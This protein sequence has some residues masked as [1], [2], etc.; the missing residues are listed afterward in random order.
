MGVEAGH[1]QVRG[2]AD[3]CRARRNRG[4]VRH[5]HPGTH[6]VPYV[7]VDA[8]HLN[9]GNAT[10]QVVSIAVIV[11]TGIAA[12]GSREILGLDVGDS[13]GETFWRGFLTSLKQRGLTGLRLV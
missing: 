9:V 3:L 10:G 13:D 12:D 1:L 5:P 7:Y 6:R 11:A 8:A 4:C 2:V